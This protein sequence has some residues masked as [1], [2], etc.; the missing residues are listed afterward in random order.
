[1]INKALLFVSSIILA[2][3]PFI[4]SNSWADSHEPKTEETCVSEEAYKAMTAEE[5]EAES[6]EV[7]E[8]D[9]GEDTSKDSDEKVVDAST[10]KAIDDEAKKENDESKE[11]CLSE[12]T[13]KELS[14]EDKEKRIDER[15]EG[16]E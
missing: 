2:A 4:V 7:C 12:N 15:C 6:V 10:K 9:E 3:S 8:G 13:F 5:K 1:M 11:N 14:A 16:S